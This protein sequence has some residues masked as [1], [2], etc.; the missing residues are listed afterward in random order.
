MKKSFT[1]KDIKANV[2]KMVECFPML[3][4]G[5]LNSLRNT[6]GKLEENYQKLA[7]PKHPNWE[8]CVPI[9]PAY[10]CKN[11]HIVDIGIYVRPSRVSEFG[12][13]E[14]ISAN[15]VYSNDG[16]DYISGDITPSCEVSKSAL[17][18]LKHMCIIDDDYIMSLIGKHNDLVH[19]FMH[20]D[21]TVWD[22]SKFIGN[23]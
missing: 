21:L 23:K 16:P 1:K 19:R 12:I 20:S 4:T 7:Y 2:A 17:I 15:F 18:V 5:F 9:Y 13:R 3:E 14:G 8:Y 11:G 22:L 6:V 10:K